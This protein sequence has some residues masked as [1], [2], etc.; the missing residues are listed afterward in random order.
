MAISVVAAPLAERIRLTG[1]GSIDARDETTSLPVTQVR[2]AGLR[3]A[4]CV[5]EDVVHAIHTNASLEQES[6]GV[7]IGLDNQ[8]RG[9]RA[10]GTAGAS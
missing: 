2:V 8:G 3:Q 1:A 5:S 10:S 9:R 4:E 6:A 7:P